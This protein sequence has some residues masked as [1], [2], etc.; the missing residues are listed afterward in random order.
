[1]A[2]FDISSLQ[3]GDV[4]VSAKGGKF[5]P[6]TSN[7]QTAGGLF[8]GF[9]VPFEPGSFDSKEVNRLN[10][11]LRPQ[12]ETVRQLQML[13]EWILTTV[14]K[15]PVKFFGKHRE[16]SIISEAYVPIVKQHDQYGPSIKAKFQVAGTG[17]CRIWDSDGEPIDAPYSWKGSEVGAK[18]HLKQLWYMG[19]SF[20]ATLECRDLQIMQTAPSATCPF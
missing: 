19:T 5:S 18:L 3:L 16:P 9:Q 2:G 14:Q 11:T 4:S 12:P 20:G 1:M 6:F 10:L 7:G 13:D 15:D 8:N 17:A